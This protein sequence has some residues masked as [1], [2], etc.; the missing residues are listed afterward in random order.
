MLNN[1]INYFKNLNADLSVWRD[2]YL[3]LEKEKFYKNRKIFL[4]I[5]RR[6]N[7]W[8]GKIMVMSYKKNMKICGDD[9]NWEYKPNFLYKSD[10]SIFKDIDMPKDEIKQIMEN[11]F[12]FYFLEKKEKLR[13]KK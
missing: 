8:E 6:S 12:S 1:V 11:L 2:N 9:I 7:Q 5:H 4:L 3:L 10:F 13:F